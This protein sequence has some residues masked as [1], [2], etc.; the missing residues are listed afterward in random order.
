MNYKKLT[1]K[2]IVEMFRRVGMNMTIEEILRYSRDNERW[3]MTKSWTEKEQ[4]DFRKWM[5]EHMPK[6]M[7]GKEQE[8]GMFLLM[9]G[10][11]TK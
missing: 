3:Y 6:G 4:D 8:A 5:I 1:D 11:T 7:I 2:F 10:W 9:W